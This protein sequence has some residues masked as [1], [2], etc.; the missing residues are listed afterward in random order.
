MLSPRKGSRL[1]LIRRHFQDRRRQVVPPGKQHLRKV[2]QSTHRG[3]TK[4][5]MGRSFQPTVGT[6][7]VD[8]CEFG[9]HAQ[10]LPAIAELPHMLTVLRSHTESFQSQFLARCHSST[11][12]RQAVRLSVTNT[13]SQPFLR[14]TNLLCRLCGHGPSTK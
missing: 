8:K 4:I 10:N 6:H 5:V 11:Q 9:R 13:R 3:T 12:S 1:C 2:S 7:P 14:P